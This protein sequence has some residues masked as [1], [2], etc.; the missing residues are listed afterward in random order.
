MSWV[1]LYRACVQFFAE[2]RHD[3]GVIVKNIYRTEGER[4]MQKLFAV[5]CSCLQ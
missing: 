2:V 5:V 1:D 3:G 4:Y